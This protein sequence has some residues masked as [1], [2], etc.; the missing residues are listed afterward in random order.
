MPT[1]AHENRQQRK[2]NLGFAS[3]I[4]QFC[5]LWDFPK[6]EK[7]LRYSESA[8][9]FFFLRKLTR[10]TIDLEDNERE[11][12]FSFFALLLSLLLLRFCSL[13]LVSHGDYPTCLISFGAFQTFLLKHKTQQPLHSKLCFWSTSNALLRIRSVSLNG[14]L[15]ECYQSPRLSEYP[16]EVSWDA[17]SPPIALFGIGWEIPFGC[18]C[19]SCSE[20]RYWA[21]SRIDYDQSLSLLSFCVAPRSSDHVRDWDCFVG[22]VNVF[23]F[24]TW[25]NYWRANNLM[26]PRGLTGFW[27]QKRWATSL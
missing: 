21:K 18:D 20:R 3:K 2:V 13:T 5:S 12:V 10:N 8:S 27:R 26:S 9:T 11:I 14:R 16:Q 17:P 19:P 7:T 1:Y 6:C 15:P 4:T 24:S 22:L 25:S 23:V